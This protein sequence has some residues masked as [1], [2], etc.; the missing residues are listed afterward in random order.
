MNE[1]PEPQELGRH[2][3]SEKWKWNCDIVPRQ[4][5]A[6]PGGDE[7]RPRE[8]LADFLQI[9]S[10]EAAVTGKCSIAFRPGRRRHLISDSSTASWS[11]GQRR[12]N[13]FNAQAPSMRAS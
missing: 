12:N 4:I 2:R 9:D 11:F 7:K 3:Q 10:H 5:P 1:A 8:K 6:C 13:A